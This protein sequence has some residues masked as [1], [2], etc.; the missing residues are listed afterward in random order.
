MPGFSGQEKTPGFV[1]SAL[2]LLACI[3]VVA[4]VLAPVAL[5]NQGTGGFGGLAAAAGIC[6]LAGFAAEAISTF[7]ARSGTPLAAAIVGMGVRMLPPL[8]LCMVLAASGQSGRAHLAFICYLLAFY[9]ATLVME[10]WLA[11]QRVAAFT[12][13]SLTQPKG[14]G[15]I[16]EPS[17]L[18]GLND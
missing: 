10:T 8:A 5:K 18:G 3:S 4:L 17:R 15:Y 16:A 1:R 13:R 11:V 9:F 2:M 6:L 12:P 14:L 7:L